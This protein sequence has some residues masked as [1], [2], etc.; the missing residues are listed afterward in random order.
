VYNVDQYKI[1]LSF[2]DDKRCWHSSN[3]SLPY[4]YIGNDYFAVFPPAE[5]IDEQT[6]MQTDEEIIDELFPPMDNCDIN[7]QIQG[8]SHNHF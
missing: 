5:E 7:I 8:E 2:A 3:F 6:R 1:A 4:G